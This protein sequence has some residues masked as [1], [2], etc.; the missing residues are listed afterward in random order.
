[1]KPIYFVSTLLILFYAVLFYYSYQYYK[2]VELVEIPPKHCKIKTSGYRGT[3]NYIIYYQGKVYDREYKVMGFSNWLWDKEDLLDNRW[4][5]KEPIYFYR[6]KSDKDVEE[7][8]RYFLPS[9]NKP[10]TNKVVLVLDIWGYFMT[11]WL[12]NIL[13]ILVLVIV[14]MEQDFK[15]LKEMDMN[16]FFLIAMLLF[17]FLVFCLFFY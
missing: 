9:A 5:Q 1:M 15:M 13:L 14:I 12:W 10:I 4:I 3:R 17:F 11:N 8:S 7:T 6:L 16:I 2:D